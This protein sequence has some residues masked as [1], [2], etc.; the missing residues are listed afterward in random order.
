MPLYNF[1]DLQVSTSAS[2]NDQILL[3]LNNS[4]SGEEGFSRITF[5]KFENSL[6][7]L[8]SGG[9]IN[10]NV[11]INGTM[12][13]NFIRA[14]SANIDIINITNYELSG[15]SILSGGLT[16]EGTI[17]SN[18]IVYA[19]GGN[20]NQWNS[21]FTTVQNSSGNWDGVSS[22]SATAWVDKLGN[23]ST[24][25]IGNIQ[26]PYLTMQSAF[27]AGAKMFHI[28]AGTF[29][30]IASEANIDISFIG[31]GSNKTEI[32]NISATNTV[33][34]SYSINV[35]D[36]GVQSALIS[37]ISS[38][39]ENSSDPTINGGNGGLITINNIKAFYVI[40]KGGNGADGNIDNVNGSNGG[41]ATTI[42]II[43]SCYIGQ[44]DSYGGTGGN[45]YD[46]GGGEYGNNGNGGNAGGVVGD[47]LY[48]YSASL[49]CYGGS[50]G[51][52][53]GSSSA[54]GGGAG[55]INLKNLE[56]SSTV[57]ID[58]G[59]YTGPTIIDSSGG[60]LTLN[61]G[62]INTLDINVSGA[63][64]Q[65]VINGQSIYINTVNGS[66]TINAVISYISGTPYGT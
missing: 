7:F 50:A 65:G 48:M 29:N 39:G 27:N 38:S 37:N 55:N 66:P 59:A 32:T 10:G 36:I 6:N 56:S 42:S 60:T 31:A 64:T 22:L 18:N 5:S 13:S 54:S 40:N 51:S 63:G 8:K 1:S 23:D 47:T 12:S 11:T 44:L 57:D 62:F 20:S 16:V 61:K 24:G 45:G 41:N 30:G 53:A 21:T 2:N 3:R 9:T 14:T 17:S 15:F 34:T 4:L 26:K 25:E 49:N 46:V 43:G 19:S 28:G 52:N 33:S 58:P 35:Q